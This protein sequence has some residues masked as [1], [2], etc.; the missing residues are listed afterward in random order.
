MS[1]EKNLGLAAG[2]AG[3]F[4]LAAWAFYIHAFAGERGEDWMVYDTAIRAFYDGNIAVL[5]DGDG[6]TQLLNA[7][8]A[9]WLAHPL[10]LHPWLYPPHYLLLLLPFGLLPFLPAGILFLALSFLGLIA[11]TCC[12][13]RAPRARAILGVAAALCPASAITACLGQN[14]FLTCALM[15]GGFG[16]LPRRPVL[17]GALLGALTY[18]P[19]LWLMVP[20]AL[21]AGR[22]WKALA[23]AAASALLLAAASAA[24]FGIAPWQQWL[25]VMTRP[26][27]LF[28][29]WSAIARLN[30]QSLFTYA[31]LLGAPAPLANAIQAL[32]IAGAAA[33]VWW[34]YRRPMAREAQLAVLFAATLLAAPHVID[35]D[36]LLLGL[37]A[38]LVFARGLER[39]LRLTETLFLVLLWVSPFFNPPTVFRA[40]FATPLLILLFIVWTLRREYGAGVAAP[41]QASLDFAR[42]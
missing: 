28:V 31:A 25:V 38:A 19:Q 22:H 40:G 14:T 23:G 30:G 35:Y 34:C 3:V 13:V 8:F 1:V 27:E 9:A 26:S 20:V 39:G 6:L 10:P 24:I 29:Q 5:Y 41:E 42:R 7:N 36:A 16:L 32:G 4:G 12:C 2:L 17:A 15:M 11:A 37:A 21:I 33:A 18:K